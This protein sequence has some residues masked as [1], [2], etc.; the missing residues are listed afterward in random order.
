MV[1][2]RVTLE[3]QDRLL[4]HRRLVVLWWMA[5]AVV[6]PVEPGCSHCLWELASSV[7]QTLV[8]PV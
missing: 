2:E 6:V 5:L 1:D 8:K 7:V 4:R 3:D